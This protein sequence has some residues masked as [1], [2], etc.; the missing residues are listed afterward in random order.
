MKKLSVIAL[1]VMGFA[2]FAAGPKFEFSLKPDRVDGLYKSGETVKFTF[3]S[4]TIDKQPIAD[5]TKFDCTWGVGNE[6]R[7]KFQVEMKGGSIV[8]EKPVKDPSYYRLTMMPLD[9]AGKPVVN[10]WLKAV[11]G[12]VCDMDKI[13]MPAG[14]MPEDFDAWW[15]A[16]VAAQKKIPM[17]VKRTV[18]GL[19]DGAD[20]ARRKVIDSRAWMKDNY[21]NT[22]SYDV[23]IKAAGDNWVAGGLSLPKKPGKFPAVL[24][25]YGVGWDG[26]CM[27]DT[28]FAR[29]HNAIIFHVNCHGLPDGAN[30]ENDYQEMKK[31]IEAY[32]ATNPAWQKYYPKI[33]MGEGREKFYYRYVFLRAAR[34]VEYI[35]TLPEWDGKTI[36]VRGCSQ[37]SA[38]AI[39]A[40]ALSEG[41]THMFLGISAMADFSGA[42]ATPKRSCGWPFNIRDDAIYPEEGYFDTVNFAH[43]LHNKKIFMAWGLTDYLVQPCGPINIYNSIPADSEKEFVCE[44]AKGHDS[45]WC[46]GLFGPRIQKL[47]LGK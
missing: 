22:Y 13:S 10:D 25:F 31:K 12:V 42:K 26:I 4:G 1:C 21:E 44:A 43:R 15:D 39:A 41:V 14:T 46:L 3:T 6:R 40:A 16:E 20:E 24:H 37:G 29:N 2:A 18:R 32:A 38:Q 7:E 30:W 36:I 47:C 23:R 8:I 34:A 19:Y 5:G 27:T 33:G 45:P 17:E 28:M 9:A 11:C 35:K